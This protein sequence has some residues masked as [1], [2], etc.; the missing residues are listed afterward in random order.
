[1]KHNLETE[2]KE[3]KSSHTVKEK[4]GASRCQ[5]REATLKKKKILLR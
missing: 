4:R 5:Y 3:S 2:K 1:M